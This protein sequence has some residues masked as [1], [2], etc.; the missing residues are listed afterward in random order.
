MAID[1]DR[2][3]HCVLCHDNLMVERLIDRQRV[4]SLGGRATDMNVTLND[5]SIMRVTICLSCKA[6]YTVRDAKRLMK[7]V[8]KGWERECEELVADETKP[9]LDA[10]WKSRH[11]KIYATKEIV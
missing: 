2:F 6:D 5:G 4:L 8:I 10:A 7:S 11:M 1:Y 3:G 9:H